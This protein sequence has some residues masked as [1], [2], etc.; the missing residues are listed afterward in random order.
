MSVTHWTDQGQMTSPLGLLHVAWSMGGDGVPS[1]YALGFDGRWPP[2]RS[3]LSR[4]GVAVE[5]S[6]SEVP[7]RFEVLL[8]RYFAGETDCLRD[9]SIVQV[10]TAFQLRVWQAL[11]A[12][13]AGETRTYREVAQE[14]GR[15]RSSRAVGAANGV[16]PL[17]LVIPCHRVVG[18]DGTLTGY[19]GGLERK[20][21]L[22]EH[23]AH[24]SS[25]TLG[26]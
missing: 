15:P 18:T 23:E 4:H 26:R 8:G 1:L 20:K 7:E 19:G 2:M 11:S 6:T 21:W 16:N 14:I 24:G 12:I 10:G 22:L 3:F 5:E 17:S 13:P 25:R 9:I